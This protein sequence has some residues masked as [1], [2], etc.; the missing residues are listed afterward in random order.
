[1]KNTSK[2]SAAVFFLETSFYLENVL[3]RNEARRSN[4]DK[5]I[6]GSVLVYG[7]T[8]DQPLFFLCLGVICQLLC[9]VWSFVAA[10]VNRYTKT[11]P[12]IVIKTKVKKTFSENRKNFRAEALIDDHKP[13][14][15]R[16][17]HKR[18]QVIATTHYGCWNNFGYGFHSL[19]IVGFDWYT[20]KN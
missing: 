1:M 13:F 17:D 16:Y 9:I 8:R 19:Y 11:E 7:F 2:I 12:G 5:V 3:K 15:I 14:T 10:L 20:C 18:M 6:L 4:M